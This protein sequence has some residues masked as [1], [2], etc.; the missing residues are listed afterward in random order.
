[1]AFI[2]LPEADTDPKLRMENFSRVTF[3]VALATANCF[4][5][6]VGFRMHR[7]G[8]AFRKI[9]QEQKTRNALLRAL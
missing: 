2:W 9:K 8:C 7:G 3:Y 1:M 5:R 4:G 6:Q